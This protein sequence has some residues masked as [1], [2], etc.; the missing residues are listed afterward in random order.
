MKKSDRETNR[1]WRWLGYEP[2][3]GPCR[4]AR[5]PEQSRRGPGLWIVRSSG[6]KTA[7]QVKE[8]RPLGAATGSLS[9]GFCQG[10]KDLTAA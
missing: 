1:T 5:A 4:P 8:A 9:K 3:N 6:D 10:M 7:G 2:E